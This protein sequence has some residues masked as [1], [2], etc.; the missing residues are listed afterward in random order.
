M[1]ANVQWKNQDRFSTLKKKQSTYDS[2]KS[3]NDDLLRWGQ[4]I[5][6]VYSR[7][8][9]EGWTLLTVEIEV[10][11]DSKSTNERGPSLAGSS[12]SS[13][14]YKRLFYPAIALVSPVQFFSSTYTISIYVSPWPCNLGRQSCRAA[15]LWMY[16]SGV[17]WGKKYFIL[18]WPEQ[19]R[20]S[21]NLWYRHDK[22]IEPTKEG[23]LLCVRFESPFTSVSTVSRG[24]LSL[25][26]L[27]YIY[28][29]NSFVPVAQ[30]AG[31]AT[32]L[33][34]LSLR[35]CLWWESSKFHSHSRGHPSL[36]SMILTTFQLKNKQVDSRHYLFWKG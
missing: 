9:R 36:V 22:P 11:G 27:L 1:D 18:V 30:Q 32:V 28:Y 34:R 15:C 24:H 14:R 10:N 4:G 6:T 16:V 20:L 13:C 7:E 33:G 17:Q 21:K 23:P 29:F 2:A 31:W 8:T 12:E 5:E 26:S 35:M 3:N 19:P 25:V